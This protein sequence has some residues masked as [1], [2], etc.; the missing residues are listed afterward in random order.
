MKLLLRTALESLVLT[1]DWF[2]SEVLALIDTFFWTGA[3]CL[4]A[5]AGLYA[6]SSDSR[7]R[8]K[9]LVLFFSS[10]F[11]FWNGNIWR[12]FF[13][14][15]QSSDKWSQWETA[16][17]MEGVISERRQSCVS[18]CSDSK[19]HCG[20]TW[21]QTLWEC[22]GNSLPQVRLNLLFSCGCPFSRQ[23]K[24]CCQNSGNQGFR[25]LFSDAVSGNNHQTTWRLRTAAYGD[26]AGGLAH[27]PV[28]DVITVRP[29]VTAKERTNQSVKT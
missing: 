17:L 25:G 22:C 9:L 21:G 29:A 20:S 24:R 16:R 8:R 14:L 5:R 10:V 26:P 15:K 4:S 1:A 27:V 28:S 6:N 18:V 19:R 12:S 2:D 13:E 23:W 7:F 3:L 11:F